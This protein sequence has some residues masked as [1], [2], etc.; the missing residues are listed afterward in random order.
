MEDGGVGGAALHCLCEASG[1]DLAKRNESPEKTA[2]D[3]EQQRD[4][5]DACV[6]ADG[7]ADGKFGERLPVREAAQE[8]ER[9]KRAEHA[10]DRGDENGFAEELT[11]DVPA[12]GADSET[13]RYFAT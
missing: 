3:G 1:P 5:I 10:A 9:K 4:E 8:C 13:N 12:A 6:G 7:Y 2:A 11:Q